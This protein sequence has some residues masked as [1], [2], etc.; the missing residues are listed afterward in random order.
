MFA[1]SSICSSISVIL[2]LVFSASCR[3]CWLRDIEFNGSSAAGHLE[4]LGPFIPWT[5]SSD[6]SND[7]LQLPPVFG[8]S[9]HSCATRMTSADFCLNVGCLAMSLSPDVLVGCAVFVLGARPRGASSSLDN[10][11]GLPKPRLD[12]QLPEFSARSPGVRR[13]TFPVSPSHIHRP[14]RTSLGFRYQRPVAHWGDASY[15]LCLPRSTSLP[16][17]S[18]PLLLA[19]LDHFV[20]LVAI[21]Q[22]DG[23]PRHQTQLLF[24]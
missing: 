17:A 13:V 2:L 14:V 24:G 12:L 9:L 20:F 16:A 1:L 7:L 21:K 3:V 19:V 6:T 4:R 10:F 22:I 15:A 8:P 11:Y 5:A 18:F 23:M